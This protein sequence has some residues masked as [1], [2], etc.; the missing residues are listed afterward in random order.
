M[1]PAAR[2]PPRRRR[3]AAEARERILEAAQK[4]LAEGGPEA[5]RLADLAADLGISHPA[6]LHHFGSRDGLMQALEERAMRALQTDLLEATGFT[7]DALERVAR[8]LG[9]EGH[10]RLLAWWVMSGGAGGHRDLDWGMLRDL[11][12]ALHAERESAAREAGAPPPDRDDSIF[13]IRLA[14]AALFGEALIGG[15]LTR[16]AGLEDEEETSRRFRRWLFEL[17]A[18]VDET[19]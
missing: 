18:R 3:P 16:S 15:L 1:S 9:D 7:A 13:A 4:R 5:I 10:A 12:D 11:A 17:L 14:A 19:R 8:T 6:I 2:P